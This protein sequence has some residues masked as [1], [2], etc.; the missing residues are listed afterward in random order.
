M[1]VCKKKEWVNWS[2]SL[3]FTPKYLLEPDNESELIEIVQRANADG[4]KIKLA[5][6]GHSSSPLVETSETLLH[7]GNFTGITRHE[8]EQQAVTF[9]TGITLHEANK[10]LKDIGQSLFNLGD[11]DVQTLAGAISTGTH[12]TGKKLQ[13]L[14]SMLSAV[15]MVDFNGDIKVF[16]EQQQPEIMKAMRTSLGAFGI[17]TEITVKTLPLFKIKRLELCTDIDVCINVFDQL[18][19]ENRSVDFYW[20]PRS[21]ET[22]IRILNEPGKGT[23]SFPFKFDLKDEQEGFV[24]EIIPKQRELKFDEMEYALPKEAG[25]P[26]FQEVRTR[27][28][29]RHRKNVAWRVLFR[30]IAADENYLS[31]HYGRDSVS[32]SLHHN[33]GLPFN[34]YFSD[35]EPIFIQYG[36]RPHWAKKHN[37]KAKELRKLYP[38]WEKFHHIRRILDPIGFFMN[39]HL[40]ELFDDDE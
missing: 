11:V 8:K 2:G 24:G 9:R 1:I 22:K 13:N 4:R 15:R 36:G 25:M 32:I 7:L 38:E 16:S 21:D 6:A 40:K 33:A 34:E 18:A 37:L 30:T 17:F 26:C 39:R 29:E 20:Y 23:K 19:E 10:Q 3:K 12:G 27:I 28:K 14:S 35:I 5:A 31:P